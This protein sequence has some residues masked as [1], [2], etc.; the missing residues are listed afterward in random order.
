MEKI[1]LFGAGEI[2]KSV[3]ELLQYRGES[4]AVG[5]FCD[6]NSEL[7]ASKC[8]VKIYIAM[9]NAKIKITNL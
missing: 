8:M 3:Y 1:I 2:G 4:D 7:C 6:N 5:C 9:M